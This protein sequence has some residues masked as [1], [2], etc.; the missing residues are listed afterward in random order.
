MTQLA[1][2]VGGG[3]LKSV[4]QL[5]GVFGALVFGL[6]VAALLAFAYKQLRGDGIEW[7]DDDD[8]DGVTQGDTDDEWKYS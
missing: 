7:P 6:F 5:A 3:L 1:L 8:A 4:A 2:Q